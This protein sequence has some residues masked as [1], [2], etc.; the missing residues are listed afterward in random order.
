MY[1]THC[2]SM[3]GTIQTLI[4][5]PSPARS[6]PFRCRTPRFPA[7]LAVASRRSLAISRTAIRACE[8]SSN[9]VRS[10]LI[11]LS[12][13]LSLSLSRSSVWLPRK[14]GEKKKNL[15]FKLSIESSFFCIDCLDFLH[16]KLRNRMRFQIEG[17]GEKSGRESSSSQG[18]PW[19]KPLL[20]FASSNFLPLGNDYLFLFFI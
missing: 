3:A 17:N 13:A 10:T 18:L 15:P 5:T 4:L 1:R 14:R 11:T 16:R 19:T 8:S 2:T 20:N 7:K 6:L 12:L 9:Q